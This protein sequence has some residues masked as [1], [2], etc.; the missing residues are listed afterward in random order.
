MPGNH[1]TRKS[2]WAINHPEYGVYVGRKGNQSFWTRLDTAGQPAVTTFS[3]LQKAKAHVLTWTAAIWLQEQV[4][5]IQVGSGGPFDLAAQGLYV[6][7]LFENL[8][9]LIAKY[10]ELARYAGG[11]Q[12]PNS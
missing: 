9:T 2:F 10:P 6:G 7:D 8:K 11:P 4:N 12:S 5:Y 1:V 3:S